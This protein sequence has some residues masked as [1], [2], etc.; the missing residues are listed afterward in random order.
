MAPE[1]YALS[2]RQAEWLAVGRGR[3]SELKLIPLFTGLST[4]SHPFGIA[5]RTELRFRAHLPE[6][7]LQVEVA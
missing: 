1:R 7:V 3:V 6:G 2:G 4:Y 5:N